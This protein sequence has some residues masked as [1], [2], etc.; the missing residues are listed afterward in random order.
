MEF[1]CPKFEK[2]PLSRNSLQGGVR[3]DVTR[4]Q[5]L[6]GMNATLDRILGGRTRPPHQFSDVYADLGEA[7]AA[8]DE[9]PWADGSVTVGPKILRL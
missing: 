3:E 9:Q 8:P 5:V 4:H 6:Y 1:Q 2:V 7:A